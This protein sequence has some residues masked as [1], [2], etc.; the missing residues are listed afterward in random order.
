VAPPHTCEG[1]F[2]DGGYKS[3]IE[4]LA[5]YLK[6]YQTCYSAPR[7][8]R[9]CHKGKPD[10]GAGPDKRVVVDPVYSAPEEL[11]A[12]LVDAVV[13]QAKHPR[14]AGLTPAETAGRFHHSSNTSK[15]AHPFAQRE[16]S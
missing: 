10:R 7:K 13:H 1:D 6:W 12:D 5:M 15:G 14:R 3:A 8:R 16:P 4:W 2:E 9:V 11:G